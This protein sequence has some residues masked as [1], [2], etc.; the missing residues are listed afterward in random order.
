MNQA[1]LSSVDNVGGLDTIG[2]ESVR[3]CLLVLT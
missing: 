3:K 1:N 2:S